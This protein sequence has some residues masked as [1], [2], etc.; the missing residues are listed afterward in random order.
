MKRGTNLVTSQGSSFRIGR[1]RSTRV[2][3]INL[4]KRKFITRIQYFAQKWGPPWMR[5]VLIRHFNRAQISKQ[6]FGM[7]QQVSLT[8]LFA[9][10]GASLVGELA[11][12]TQKA[13]SWYFIFSDLTSHYSR[14]SLHRTLQPN[15]SPCLLFYPP[16]RFRASLQKATP[17]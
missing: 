3:L 16:C 2:S 12:K 13:K 10:D 8:R 1:T 7:L 4:Q 17:R 5:K 15:L 9:Q 6:L 14:T 11:L